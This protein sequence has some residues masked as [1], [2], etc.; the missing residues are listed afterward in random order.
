ML[1]V[2]ER[3]GVFPSHVIGRWTSGVKAQSMYHV[4]SLKFTGS[5]VEDVDCRNSFSLQK[6]NWW[7]LASEMKS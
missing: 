5:F 7:N 2:Q 3:Y 6:R 1:P 4:R